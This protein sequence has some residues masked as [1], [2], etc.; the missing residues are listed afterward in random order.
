MDA[1]AEF[2]NRTQALLSPS[3]L[4]PSLLDPSF[5]I[6]ASGPADCG[7]I[8]DFISGLSVRTQFLR[9]FA[10]VAPPSA[11]LLRGLCGADGR[12][13]VILATDSRGAVIGHAMTVDR[14]AA[15]GLRISDVGLVVAD[16]WQG[17]GVGSALLGAVV[18]G[19]SA[20][21]VS[22][23][24]M[25]VLPG[26]DKMLAMIERRWPGARRQFSA[27]SVTIRACLRGRGQQDA[28]GRCAA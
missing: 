27:D 26:N 6:R 2:M 14:T 15:D 24:V 8:R 16:G 12:A 22:T 13:L 7:P 25:D 21:G 1:Q 9:F 23:L 18:A 28:A 4:S 5:A 19:A 17:R 11:G 20:R 10:S 3:V